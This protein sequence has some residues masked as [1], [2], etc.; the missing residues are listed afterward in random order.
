[1]STDVANLPIEDIY[2]IYAGWH[3]EHRDIFSVPAD[4]FNDVQTRVM[5]TF[6]KHLVHLGY[7]SIKP[8]RLGFFLDEQAGVFSA[9][10]DATECVVV[11]DGLETIDQPVSGRLRPLYTRRPVQLV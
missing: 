11:T 2:A 7:D 9:V 3:A 1:M 4:Q 10:R 8:A 5:G 6:Q